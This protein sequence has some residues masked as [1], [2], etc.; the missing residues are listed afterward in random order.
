M[1]RF[2][3][4][5]LWSADLTVQA[6][7]PCAAADWILVLFCLA[8]FEN[9]RVG[10]AQAGKSFR[11]VTEEKQAKMGLTPDPKMLDAMEKATARNSTKGSTAC[12]EPRLWDDGLIDPRDT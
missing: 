1:P 6:T 10:G 11:I 7:M 9:G 8:K 4:S 5:R 2:R 12:T 3:E